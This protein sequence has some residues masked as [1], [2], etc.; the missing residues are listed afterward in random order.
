MSR[1]NL[2]IGSV[3]ILAAVAL[4]AVSASAVEPAKPSASDRHRLAVAACTVLEA[5]PD[6]SA[7][8]YSLLYLRGG[9]IL[10]AVTAAP[11]REGVARGADA[12]GVRR[13]VVRMA[14]RFARMPILRG[15]VGSG[16]EPSLRLFHPEVIRFADASLPPPDAVLCHGLTASQVYDRH[17]RREAHILCA[18]HSFLVRANAFAGFT[19]EAYV[20]EIED[21]RSVAAPRFEPLA[22]EFGED[23]DDGK[24]AGVSTLD[25]V[26]ARQAIGFWFR[27]DADGTRQ[28]VV[29]LV[30][31]RLAAYERAYPAPSGAPSDD[32]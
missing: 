19:P 31:V 8:L 6:A 12:A 30:C 27:R 10:S 15:T 25:G 14:A 1:P 2:T 7:G 20:R 23:V 9:D 11:G 16:S 22:E 3:V 21:P 32:L 26:R 17:L 28:A 29:T 24:V 5:N 4:A 13:E 18:A